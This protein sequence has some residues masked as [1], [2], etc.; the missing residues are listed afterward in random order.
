MLRIDAASQEG[1]DAKKF[2]FTTPER[3]QYDRLVAEDTNVYV[4]DKLTI[5]YRRYNEDDLD[6]VSTLHRIKFS[7]GERTGG[8]KVRRRVFGFQP[9]I[10][11][12]ND[13]CSI[14]TLATD[15]PAAHETIFDMGRKLSALYAEALPEGHA[16]HAAIMD[17]KVLPE[18]RIPG[19]VYTSGI[20]NENSALGYHFDTGNFKEC[21]SGMVVFPSRVKGGELI[22]PEFRLAFG[23]EKPA[24]I[25]FD[26]QAILHGVGSLH[27]PKV[28]YRY[29][30]V[31]YS[32]KNVC[33][34]LALQ[35]EIERA[36]D[37]RTVREKRRLLYTKESG[38]TPTNVRKFEKTGKI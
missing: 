27:R 36:K 33:N 13:Y 30:I 4:K 22:L 28:G 23:F 11:L 15:D 14:A 26:G 29:S 9:R 19:T 37:M 3:T 5:I 2:L 32:L 16:K 17:A 35:Q 7:G 12:R 6:M 21:W 8:L 20:I 25:F 1:F 24:I 34:C 38:I 10:A 18:W 31:F